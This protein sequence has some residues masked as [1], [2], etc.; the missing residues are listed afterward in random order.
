MV[1][2]NKFLIA[3]VDSGVFLLYLTLVIIGIISIF[4]VEYSSNDPMMYSLSKSFMKQSIFFGV[5]LF[6][7]LIILFT[8]S[9]VFNSFAYLAYTIGLF[10][11]IITIFIGKDIKGSHSWLSLGGFT[12]QP[13]EV[14]KI[15]T[16]LALTKYLSSP[17]VN[18][19]ILKDRLIGIAIAM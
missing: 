10:L 14:C 18:F 19:Q 13:G 7:G 1:N 12:F 17:E 15:F 16:A 5:S 4:S 8:D 11:L 3:R 2:Y 9:K 6:I